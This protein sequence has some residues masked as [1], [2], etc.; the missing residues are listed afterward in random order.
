MAAV[1]SKLSKALFALR[2]TKNYLTKRALISI[3]YSLFHSH[4]VYAIE[5]WSCTNPSFLTGLFK[6]QKT[7]VRIIENVRYNTHTEPIFKKLE[8]LPLPELANY[9]KIQ[10]MQKF[11]Q[12]TL[13]TLLS[14]TWLFNSERIIGENSLTLRNHY[15]INIPFVRLSSMERHPLIAF[16]KLWDDFQD[17][18]IKIIRNRIEFCNKLKEYYIKNLSSTVSCNRVFCPSCHFN[19]NIS[20]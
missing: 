12:K 8:I 1:R 10:F 14:N 15:Q 13:P 20:P 19:P 11:H 6:L 18:G 17:N 2:M 4:L 9:F 16:P 7:A 5:T 3:Y